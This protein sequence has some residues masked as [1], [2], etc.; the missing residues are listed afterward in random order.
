MSQEALLI[1]QLTFGGNSIGNNE[2]TEDIS[3]RAADTISERP[4]EPSSGTLAK[5]PYM[6]ILHA[7]TFCTCASTISLRIQLAEF[8]NRV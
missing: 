6:A 1:K 5:S 8:C 7:T 3:E 2:H 4:D